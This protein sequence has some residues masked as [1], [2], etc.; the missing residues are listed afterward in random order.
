MSCACHI[1]DDFPIIE[2]PATQL[3]LDSRC[4]TSLDN[5]LSIFK[6]I[7]IPITDSKTQGPSQALEFMG[8]LLDTSKIQARLA[9]DKIEKLN[10]CVKDF[11]QRKSCTLKELQSLIGTL[12]FACKVV[13]PGRPFSQRMI[14]LTRNVLKTY[15]HIRLN[16]GFFQDLQMW[17]KFISHWNG[18]FLVVNLA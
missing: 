18:F 2:P 12:N 9:S 16:A 5:M 13:P 7:G 15:H 8:I 4:Q 10:G 6:T 17:K 1:L 14:A 11:E 3:P